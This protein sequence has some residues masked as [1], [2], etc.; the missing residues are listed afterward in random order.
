MKNYLYILFCL[1]GNTNFKL[2]CLSDLQAE[3][4][5][6]KLSKQIWTVWTIINSVQ[7]EFIFNLFFLFSYYFIKHQK[8]FSEKL[9]DFL[10]CC[11]GLNVYVPRQIPML[12]F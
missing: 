8:Y 10:A 9:L 1:G 7:C 12:K 11:Y 2:S 4:S 6:M 5:K 3:D